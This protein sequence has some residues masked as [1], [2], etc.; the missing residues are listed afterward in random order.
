MKGQLGIFSK[1]K[2]GADELAYDPEKEKPIIRAS[3]CTSEKVAGFKDLKTGS[4]REVMLIREQ[5]D[6]EQFKREYGIDRLDTEY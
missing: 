1:K 2:N 3:I 6:L 5:R 4:F